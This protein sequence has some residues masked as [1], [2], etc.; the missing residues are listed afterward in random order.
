MG[1][2]YALKGHPASSLRG[3]IL[4]ES[5]QISWFLRQSGGGGWSGRA[6]AQRRPRVSKLGLKGL[7]DYHS[8]E[9]AVKAA[10]WEASGPTKR[11][12]LMKHLLK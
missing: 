8:S 6:I 3:I 2:Y 1:S 11:A 9:T 5:T 10:R 4:V 12:T 7:C